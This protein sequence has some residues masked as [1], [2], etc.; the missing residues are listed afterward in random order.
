MP[1]ILNSTRCSLV[2][3]LVAITLSVPVAAQGLPGMPPGMGSRLIEFSGA[4]HSTAE[5]CGDYSAAQ[6]A[7]MKT[8][9]K[10]MYAQQGLDSKSFNEAF[11]KGASDGRKRWASMS[12]AEQVAACKDI[13]QQMS[14]AGDHYSN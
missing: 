2:V 3:A 5:A 10:T 7:K 6:L 9:Q 12:K 8:E 13:K 4:M 11:A 14:A 1:S